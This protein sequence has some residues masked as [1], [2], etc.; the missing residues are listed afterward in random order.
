MCKIDFLPNLNAKRTVKSTIEN[1][2]MPIPKWTE[3]KTAWSLVSI[4]IAPNV[5]C[6]TTS[7]LANELVNFIFLFASLLIQVP[8][9]VATISTP[10]VA[11]ISR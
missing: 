7:A 8:T 6:V 10:V 1:K 2:S 9:M 4:T 11:A 3:T 5:I